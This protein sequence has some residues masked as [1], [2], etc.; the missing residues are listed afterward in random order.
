MK[1]VIESVYNEM[2]VRG[3]RILLWFP[4]QRP[5]RSIGMEDDNLSVSLESNGKRRGVKSETGAVV[6]WLYKIY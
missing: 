2:M 3:M 6:S 1:F 5:L 4:V